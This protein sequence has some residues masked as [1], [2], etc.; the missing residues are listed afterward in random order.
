VTIASGAILQLDF[1]AT[2]QIS[3]LVTNGISAGAGL[4]SSV[5]A[6]PYVTGSGSLLVVPGPSGPAHLTNSVSGT[7]L[8][9]TWPAGQGWRLVSQTNNLAAGLNPNPAAWG[10]VPGA[11]DGNA[12]I[13]LD[14]SKPAVFY[15]LVYP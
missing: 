12:A 1:T 6:S 9:L 11:G 8:S 15:Q 10:S 14:P 5:N 4:Y 3:R 13:S 7:T 2:N